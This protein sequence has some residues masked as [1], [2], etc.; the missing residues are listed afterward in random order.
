MT[1]LL[2]KASRQAIALALAAQEQHPENAVD[3]EWPFEV[4]GMRLT[5]G[6]ASDQQ[7]A[8]LAYGTLVSAGRTPWFANY[9]DRT[10]R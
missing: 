5:P 2:A 6:H 9:W 8:W 4:I 7:E 10:S 1:D 3:A